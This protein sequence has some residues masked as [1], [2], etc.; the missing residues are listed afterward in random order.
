MG[1]STFQRVLVPIDFTEDTDVAVH[2]GFEIEVGGG[3]VAVAPASARALELAAAIIDREGELCLVHA[4]PSYES[5]RV[6]TGGASIGVLGAGEIAEVHASAREASLKVLDALAKHFAPD[7]R[8]RF[9][10]RPG[11]ALQVILEEAE[12][13]DAQLLVV[14]ASGRSRV[15]R[16]FL[17]S[18]A[19]RIIR[20]APCPVL[21]VPPVVTEE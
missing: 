5:A 11:V 8:C 3:T 7:I 1:A 4:T 15:A 13:F 20:Q 6:Y 12:R 2:S 9:A 21:V 10:V 19:D 17:G 14:A 16:F 18:T